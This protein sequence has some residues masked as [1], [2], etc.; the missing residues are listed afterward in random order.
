MMSSAGKTSPDKG[1]YKI[2]RRGKKLM[3]ADDQR[4]LMALPKDVPER[5]WAEILQKE[6]DDLMILDIREEI[7]EEAMKICYDKYMERQNALFTAH[8]AAKAWLKLIDWYF[9]RH[10]PGEEPSAY[11]PCYIPKRR[12]SWTPDT[13]PDPCPKD[14]WCQH[15]LMVLEDT[16]EEGIKK[17]PSSSSIDYPIVDDIPSDCCFPGK[18]NLPFESETDKYKTLSYD[19][20]SVTS[21]PNICAESEILQKITDYSTEEISHKESTYS[22]L[23]TTTPVDGSLHGAGDSIVDR[24][25]P[26]RKLTEKSKLFS[27]PSMIGRSKATLPPLDGDSRS[28]ISIISDCR[29]RN[30]RLDTQYEITSEKIDT[31]PGETVKRK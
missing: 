31:P 7:I 12:E 16:Q 15:D 23:K 3:L 10:D 9:Y 13:P 19:S 11:P 2:S 4:T 25:R 26:K 22:A 30:L 20:S 17:W 14:T 21:E 8:C 24:L 1:K 28:R 27:R 6:E 29:L 18:V 5:T